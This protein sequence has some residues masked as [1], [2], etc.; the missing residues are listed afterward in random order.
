LRFQYELTGAGWSSATLAN[1][2]S[3][4]RLSASYLSDALGNLISTVAMVVEGVSSASCSWDE[5]PGE[6]RWHF[7]RQE[8]Q[9]EIKILFFNELWAYRPDSEGAPVFAKK[10]SVDSVAR[11]FL[12]GADNILA[13]MS[14]AEY[15]AKWGEHDYPSH[16]VERLRSAF[17]ALPVP[18]LTWQE[19]VR[20]RPEMYFGCRPSIHELATAVAID[21]AYELIKPE[22]VLLVDLRSDGSVQVSDDGA[23]I[24]NQDHMGKPRLSMLLG[25][26]VGAP[27]ERGTLGPVTAFCSD[28]SIRS[29]S[30][31]G[32]QTARVTLGAVDDIQQAPYTGEP[33]GT[34][35]IF[36]VDPKHCTPGSINAELLR[37]E[38]ID[39]AKK[40][41]QID[42]ANRIVVTE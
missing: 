35:I 42:I 19:H 31:D 41:W 33:T 10:Y 6:Y 1:D 37:R 20:R 22:V 9:I 3:E 25:L 7:V 27:D 8:D 36:A 38:V 5:E 28:F 30:L 24:P 18:V 4:V 16:A 26:P 15:K 23:G 29:V 12:G 39:T 2:D 17:R 13:S 34:V 21:A 14:L 32:V 11:A 40:R